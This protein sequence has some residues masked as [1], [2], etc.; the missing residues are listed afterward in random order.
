[1]AIEVHFEKRI[2]NANVVRDADTKYR[3]EYV[4]MTCLFATF[5]FC[6]FFYGWQHYRWITT[7][8]KIEEAQKQK[9]QLTEAT[10]QLRLERESLRNLQRIDDIA[11]RNLGMVLPAPGQIVIFNADAP[12]TIPRP[13]APEHQDD[14]EQLAAKR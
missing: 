10:R 11:R 5:L 4:R 12:L 14:P 2:N 13:Q 7:G 1:M 9:E 3:R 6:L 8:Y